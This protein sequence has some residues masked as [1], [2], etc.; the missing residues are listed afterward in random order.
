MPPLLL[1][2]ACGEQKPNEQTVQDF[3]N[4]FVQAYADG[5]FTDKENEQLSAILNSTAGLLP[6]SFTHQ[7]GDST[8]LLMD[9]QGQAYKNHGI[10]STNS[11]WGNGIGNKVTQARYDFLLKNGNDS[12]ATFTGPELREFIE[13]AEKLNLQDAPPTSAV[14]IKQMKRA[15]VDFIRN[16][17]TRYYHDSEATTLPQSLSSLIK[18]V[19]LDLKNPDVV[20]MFENILTQFGDLTR[21][22]TDD[23]TINTNVVDSFD[24]FIDQT[25][26]RVPDDRTTK[27]QFI[28]TLLADLK[29]D[30]KNNE[31]KLAL[32]NHLFL[33]EET[34]KLTVDQITKND[35]GKS[36]VL[37]EFLTNQAREYFSDTDSKSSLSIIANILKNSDK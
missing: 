33:F 26:Q 12:R 9:F 7:S 13:H 14:V 8:R 15:D 18:D 27:R 2:L 20:L 30:P 3:Q 16:F 6:D 35:G 24:N 22:G 19:P 4:N 10:I 36:A 29:G 31:V 23:T 37:L 17:C 11:I 25:L 28:T 21:L 34:D 5:Q 32:L 1:L